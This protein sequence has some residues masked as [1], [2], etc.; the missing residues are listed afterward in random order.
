MTI[1][2]SLEARL[3]QALYFLAFFLLLPEYSQLLVQ[4]SYEELISW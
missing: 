1:T 3:R 2:Y 4:E